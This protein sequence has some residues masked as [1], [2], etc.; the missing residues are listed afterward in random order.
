LKH[1][2][3]ANLFLAFIK[4]LGLWLRRLSRFL[5]QKKLFVSSL[6]HRI[7]SYQILFEYFVSTA[8]AYGLRQHLGEKERS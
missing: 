3:E 8:L 4:A 1:P 6:G 7:G 5:R 2:V